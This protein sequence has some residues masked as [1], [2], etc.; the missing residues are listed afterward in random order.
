MRIEWTED[1]RTRMYQ[2]LLLTWGK[3]NL[4]NFDK[5]G[6]PFNLPKK[7]FISK[8]DEI[9]YAL[10]LGE[11]KGKALSNQ[12]AWAFRTPRS[13]AHAGHWNNKHKN[14]QAAIKAGYFDD[15]IIKE[16]VVTEPNIDTYSIAWFI[17]FIK[18]LLGV[19]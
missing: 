2:S 12:I 13:Y 16:P 14:E 11:N 3:P 1:L 9:G 15:Y 18:K 17:L 5:N 19:K 7:E 4:I 6:R 10:G 8:L